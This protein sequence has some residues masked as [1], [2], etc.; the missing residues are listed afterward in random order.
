MEWVFDDE[1]FTHIEKPTLYKIYV[2][3][4]KESNSQP[5]QSK[6]FHADVKAWLFQNK[7]PYECTKTNVKAYGESC[8]TAYVYKNGSRTVDRNNSYYIGFDEEET[9]KEY[10]VE[11]LGKLV[12]ALPEGI[13]M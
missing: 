12:V 5:K 8:T 2:L 3:K 7:K 10:I 11:R 9:R 4:C 1:E 6:N 13:E